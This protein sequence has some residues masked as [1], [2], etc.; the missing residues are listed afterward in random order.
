MTPADLALARA[1]PLMWTPSSAQMTPADL[2]LARALPLIIEQ[3][4]RDLRDEVLLCK[5]SK[6]SPHMKTTCCT[7][8]A[9][10]KAKGPFVSW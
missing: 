4:G 9:L 6:G 10:F 3:A 8:S 5:V 1:L 7:A 2:A